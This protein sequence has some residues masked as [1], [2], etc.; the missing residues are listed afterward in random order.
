MSAREEILARIRSRLGRDSVDGEPVRTGDEID[1]PLR[2]MVG[3][4]IVAHFKTKAEAIAA[5]VEVVDASEEVPGAIAL[6]LDSE[7]LDREITTGD[8]SWLA[9]MPWADASI[10]AAVR[11]PCEA[12][13][14]GV[15]HAAFALAETGTAVLASGSDNPVTL[16]Y[17]ADY[18]IVVVERSRVVAFQEEVWKTIREHGMPRALCFITG[19]S[20]TGDIE[21]D[22]QLGAHGPRN[23]HVIVVACE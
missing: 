23:L 4:D 21:F 8:D 5:T 14:V 6:Y 2:P 12:D 20:R 7:G 22:I 1:P 15:S 9:G 18:H 10:E 3:D 13:L 17:L 19:P 11:H 16:N